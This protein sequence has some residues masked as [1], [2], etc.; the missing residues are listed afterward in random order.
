MWVK[1]R[2]DLIVCLFCCG[3]VFYYVLFLKKGILDVE[4]FKEKLVILQVG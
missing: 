4:V 2:R 3:C 1:N